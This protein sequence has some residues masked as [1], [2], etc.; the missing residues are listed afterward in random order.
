[1]P[2]IGHVDEQFAGGGLHPAL[3]DRDRLSQIDGVMGSEDLHIEMLEIHAV[4]LNRCR[5][6][7]QPA[8]AGIAG[9]DE[10][11]RLLD[12]PVRGVG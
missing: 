1:V 4:F 8:I 9:L 11:L 3:E 6:G 2:V 5:L 7:H 10:Q 12:Q